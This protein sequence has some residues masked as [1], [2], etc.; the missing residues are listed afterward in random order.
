VAVNRLLGRTVHA[1][2]GFSAPYIRSAALGTATYAL[3]G[4]T[5][6]VQALTKRGGGLLASLAV[7]GTTL[8]SPVPYYPFVPPAMAHGLV[9][10]LACAFVAVWLEAQDHPD[11]RSW[12]VLGAL[13][14]LLA[15]TRWQCA[16]YALMFLPLLPRAQPRR[17]AL[18]AV[19]A[20]LAFAPQL[21]AWA[22]LFGSPFAA[23]QR[24]HGMDWS[25]PHL[26][27]VLF[28]AD[29]GL[30]SWTP[31]MAIG[32]LGLLALPR[33]LRGFAVAAALVLLASAW[34]NGGVREWTASDA[35]G[36]RRFDLAVPLLAV[37]ML[38][39]VQATAPLVARW[40][41][42]PA[43]GL[44]AAAVAWNLGLMRLY[45]IR[46]FSEA[47]P[48]ETIAA[49]QVHQ[50]RSLA[51]GAFLRLGGP[52]LR[53]L[54]YDFF[55]GEYFY[56]NVN[57]DGA[58]DVGA[59]ENRFLGD[60]WSPPQRRAG[61]PAFRWAFHPRACV[62]VPLPRPAPLRSFLRA[63]APDGLE[64]QSMTVTANGRPVAAR[65]L[66]AEWRDVPFEVPESALHAGPNALCFEF[67]RGVG[68][69]EQ[70]QAAAAVSLL[71]LP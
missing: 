2:D 12:V 3:A 32:T 40:P 22:V 56:W 50:V 23:P 44:L 39:G 19:A 13:L 51:E 20:A 47:A 49:R 64:S 45:R 63:R 48:L 1:A 26:A 65:S 9:F 34:V 43:A 10:G 46:V 67:A 5:L 57:L 69:D 6:L 29:R 15:L 61:W 36:A 37:G 55:V 52:R 7:A 4:A 54:A 71:Q 21:L 70:R 41:W 68:P 16:V 58:I 18:A 31:A 30:Y 14:G 53:N 66:A 42:L 33:R 8:A 59:V 28:S 11:T 60:G 24:E 25:S 62:M 35:F 27:G 38:A 17:V